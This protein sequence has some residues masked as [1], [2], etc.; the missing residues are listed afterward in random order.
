MGKTINWFSR[1]SPISTT[2]QFHHILRHFHACSSYHSYG[3]C[4]HLIDAKALHG[5]DLQNL[6]RF[7]AQF[8]NQLA[9]FKADKYNYIIY[10]CILHTIYYVCLQFIA[11][12][13]L[14]TIWISGWFITLHHFANLQKASQETY[15]SPTMTCHVLK[16]FDCNLLQGTTRPPN[17]K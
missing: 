16:Y 1:I 10:Y 11:Y 15:P 13:T 5:V 2:R 4:Y 17:Q 8:S 7:M 6:N 9:T 14:W 12:M 3:T